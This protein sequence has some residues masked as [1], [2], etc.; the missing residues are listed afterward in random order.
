MSYTKRADGREFNESRKITVKVGV[1]PR[2]DGSAMFS[3][4]DSIAIA[5]VYGPK[6]LHPQHMQDP[7]RGV[8]RVHYDMQSFSVT[9]RKKPGPNRRSSEISKVMEWS[10]RPLLQLDSFPNTVVD[11]YVTI[12]QANASTRC[13][14]INAASVALAAAGI[15]MTDL[16]TAVSVGKIDKTLVVDVIKEEEDYGEGEG[17]TD[18]PLAFFSNSDKIS[19]LQLD[20]TITIEE[21]KKAIE[22][23]KEACKSIYAAQKDALKALKEGEN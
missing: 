22:L 19:L 11:L 8:L 15:P 17:A 20:G 9:E 13:A 21:M 3:F 10:L 5:A 16:V 4:G 23:G 2:A 7:E 12:V 6:P 1:I 18:I 14:A